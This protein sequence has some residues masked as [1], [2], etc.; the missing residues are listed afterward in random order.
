MS[1]NSLQPFS[2]PAWVNSP[3]S[4]PFYN[5]SHR[6]LYK[7][8]VEWAQKHLADPVAARWER[9]AKRDEAVYQQ[10]AKD[11][12][13]LAFACG[14]K[15]DP[16]WAAR[17]GVSPP[18]GIKAEEWS[19]FHDFV[20]IDALSSVG[21]GS[22]LMGL[23]SG[24]AY[25]AGPIL[26]FGSRQLQERLLPDLL[27][28]KETTCLAI[29]EPQAGSDVSN[30][31]ETTAT[32]SPDGKYYIVNGMKKWIT[33]G[34][35]ASQFTTLVRTSGKPGDSKGLSF[36]VI[37]RSE[38][39]TTK[40]MSMIG[41]HGSG[42]TLV[43]FDEVKV[44][45]EN[46]IGREGEAL[47]YTFYNF[48]HERMTIAY[49]SLR[50]SRVC[51]EDAFAHAKRRIVFGKPLIEQP[52][53]RHKLA[54][55]AREVEALQSWCETLTYEQSQLTTEQSNVAT[56]GRCALLKAHAGIVFEKTARESLQTLGGL[57]LTKGGT[58]ERI[59]RLYREVQ[60]MCI[61]GGS[62][63]VLLDLGVRQELKL[64]QSRSKGKL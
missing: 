13:I 17:A 21:S 58:G 31:G 15:I 2:E 44:P 10:A 60:M 43:E 26:H 49:I 46:L 5:D 39:V 37:P 24:I 25:G 14:T 56:G 64:I 59:E 55:C 32:K 53:V 48:N 47:K 61:P 12:I 4:S 16:Q 30:V 57:G 50:Y 52:V 23:H 33:N 45:V 51:L 54:Q 63:D 1:L 34:I 20:L 6:A 40:Q 11:G 36:L 35:Y 62:E 8:A 27:S 19:A 22:A 42:T 28:G 29:T 7:W 18:A 41:A 9:A 38:G 3:S